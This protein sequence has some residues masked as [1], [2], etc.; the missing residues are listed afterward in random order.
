MQDVHQ[1][2]WPIS[3]NTVV[4]IYALLS[5]RQTDI[6]IF[7]LNMSIIS[8]ALITPLMISGKKKMKQYRY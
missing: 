6:H 2:A 5:R 1:L 7:K 4:Y 3:Q 8:L